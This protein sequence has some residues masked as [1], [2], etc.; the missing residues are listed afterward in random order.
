MSRGWIVMNSSFGPLRK[1]LRRVSPWVY[2]FILPSIV[3]FL[4]F[5]L[6]PI[7]E[8]LYT[9]FTNWRG[10]IRAPEFIFLDNYI[11][12]FKSPNFLASLRNLLWWTV[13]A[14]VLHVGFGT[15]TAFIL[16]RKPFGWRFT[17]SVFMIPNVI[18]VAAWAIMFRSMFDNERGFINAAVRL[19]EPSFSVNWL[20]KAPWSF[21]LVTFT[22]LFFAVVVTLIVQG[23]LMAIPQELHEAARID[24]ASDL[25]VVWRVDLPLCRGSIGTGVI[26][27]VTSRIAMYESI[28]LTTG[29][30][31]GNSTINI[32]ILMFNQIK[33]SHFGYANSMSVIMIL[34]GFLTL[35][36]VSKVFR[37]N[38]SYY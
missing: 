1:K 2:A 32:P 10:G 29:G 35:L 12:L 34:I 24:G 4:M 37:T 23:D 7:I 30:G 33:D 17:R 19:F 6:W 8:T 31:P 18:S 5:Y 36:V 15:L 9:S 16:Y 20:A 21:W 26:L 28:V 13:I 3:V 38:E 27:S 14:I 11:R 22:W 25:Q